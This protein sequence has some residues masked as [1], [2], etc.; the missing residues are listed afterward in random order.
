LRGVIGHREKPRPAIH[1]GKKRGE[2]K[3]PRRRRRAVLSIG[4]EQGKE[5]NPDTKRCYSWNGRLKGIK[6]GDFKKE[7]HS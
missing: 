3:G 6:E 1:S 4:R 5:I 7:E 2:R